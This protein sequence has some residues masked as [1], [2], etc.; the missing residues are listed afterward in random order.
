MTIEMDGWGAMCN[1]HPSK[2][3]IEDG[4]R[5]GRLMTALWPKNGAITFPR[6]KNPRLMVIKI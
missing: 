3:I 2:I 5:R 1:L 6:P 4:K